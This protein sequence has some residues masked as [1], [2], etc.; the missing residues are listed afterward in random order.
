[1]SFEL[2]R[3]ET[4][5]DGIRRVVCERIDVAVGAL[6]AKRGKQRRNRIG[7]AAVHEARKRF[8]QVRG[9]LRMVRKE[10]GGREFDRE[11]RT[12]RDAG[13]PLSEVRD[14]KVMLETLDELAKHYNGKLAAGSFKRLRRALRARRRDVRKRVLNENHATGSILKAVK[15]SSRGARDWPLA[16]NGWRAIAAGLQRTYRQGRDAMDEAIRDGSDEAFHEWRKRAKDL[17]Y[18]IELLTRAW[19][20]TMQP[21]ADALHHLT[22]LLGQDHDLAVLQG[23]VENEL[24]HVDADDERELLR[25]LVSQRRDELLKEARELGRKLYAEC[26]NDFIDRIHGYWKAWR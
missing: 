2:K 11:N 16:H 23:I 24:K 13:R 20:E 26:D 5:P 1:M 10:L 8:K 9:A 25:A 6:D 14:A 21:M 18:G 3:K 19:P 17:R 4:V 12:F 15:Q 7:D 22:D